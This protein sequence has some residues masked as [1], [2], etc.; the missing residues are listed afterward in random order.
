MAFHPE[1][2]ECLGP[3]M[4]PA[5]ESEVLRLPLLRWPYFWPLVVIPAYGL[6][7]VLNLGRAWHGPFWERSL[8]VLMLV[9]WLTAGCLMATGIMAS[10]WRELRLEN[11]RLLLKPGLE[12]FPRWV[13]WTLKPAAAQ[14]YREG[15]LAIPLAQASLEWVGT[16]LLLH[17]HPEIEVPL[18]RGS[19]AEAIAKWLCD[20]G[21]ASPV[22]R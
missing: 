3:Q 21:L 1:A 7:G 15:Q 17:G 20:Q 19:R 6:N 9:L 5:V 16:K 11:G 8:G 18:G 13:R 14:A 10:R 12:R 2:I 4:N 22:G